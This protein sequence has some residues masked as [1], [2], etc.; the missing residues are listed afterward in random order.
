MHP[1]RGFV[2]HSGAAREKHLLEGFAE[3]A[4]HEV[5][6]KVDGRVEE[7]DDVPDVAQRHVDV[8][9][10]VGVDAGEEGEDALRQLGDDEAEH[11]GDEHGRRAVVLGR[12]LRLGALPLRLEAPPLLVRL[13]HGVDEQR[14]EHREQDARSDLQHDAKQP[15]VED[16][17]EGG[18]EVVLLEPPSAAVQLHRPVHDVVGDTE[19]HCGHEH[20]QYRYL[21]SEQ[22]TQFG[23]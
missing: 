7:H 4:R 18:D 9:E 23:S 3:L 17:H 13:R 20:G 5:E 6:D 12:A 22:V 15:E 19:Q 8:H 16:L 10:D 1:V 14:A 2:E 21:S 11:D